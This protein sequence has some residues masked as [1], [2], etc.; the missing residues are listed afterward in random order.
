MLNNILSIA[1]ISFLAVMIVLMICVIIQG[2]FYII[3]QKTSRVHLSFFAYGFVE[4]LLFPLFYKGKQ[5]DMALLYSKRKGYIYVLGLN[6]MYK[7]GR[8]KCNTLIETDL[9]EDEKILIN[10]MKEDCKKKIIT[11]KTMLQSASLQYEEGS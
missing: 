4:G 5:I 10:E 1:L 6:G 3:Y 11:L 8:F 9:T 7:I 2:I